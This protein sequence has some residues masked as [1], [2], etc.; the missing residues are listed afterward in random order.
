MTTKKGLWLVALA[1]IAS[2]WLAAACSKSD[3]V[4]GWKAKVETINGVRTVRNPETPRY[5]DFAFELAEDLAI[6]DEKNE[7]YFLPGW[8]TICIDDQGK[9]YACDAGNRRVQVYDRNGVFVRTLGRQGQGPG[10]YAYPSSVHIDDAGNIYVRSSRSLVV[11]GPDGLFIKNVPL[12]TFL[13]ALI[14]GPGGTIVGTTQPN[15]KAEGGPKNELVQLSPDGDLQRKIAQFPAYGVSKGQLLD[16]WYTGGISFCPQSKDSLFYGFSLE[17]EIHA[18]DSEGRMLLAFS[19]AEKAQEIKTEERDLTREKGIYAWSGMGDPKTA[20]LGMPDHR[21][22]FWDFLSDDLGRLYVVR[23]RPI[24]EKD[25]AARDI[26]VFS[27]DGLYLYRLA[28]PFIPEVIKG[29]FLYEV[30]QDEDAG[31]TRIIRHR[32]KNWGDFKAE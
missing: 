15:P 28:W 30:R 23:F 25:I 19:K 16:H 5:G 18:V 11:F 13:S 21:P 14:L 2:L 26:D 10:E 3:S 31:L 6:G 27:K 24:T 7:S 8:V 29:G 4:A 9:I 22:F 1:L 32:I 12:K 17:Y 20:D